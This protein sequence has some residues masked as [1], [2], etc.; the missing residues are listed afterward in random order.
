[1]SAESKSQHN[2]H[3]PRYVNTALCP[4][5]P[6]DTTATAFVYGGPAA[7]TNQLAQ[8]ERQSSVTDWIEEATQVNPDRLSNSTSA[9]EAF[10]AV[11]VDRLYSDVVHELGLLAQ[12]GGSV[13]GAAAV[14]KRVA[15][16]HGVAAAAVV[17]LP[18]LNRAELEEFGR[19]GVSR[20][21]VR[22][23]L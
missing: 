6:C 21:T 14:V 9:L 4:S 19:R 23:E 15:L 13:T 16:S 1:M 2:A 12:R 20:K 11:D 22:G 7:N 5:Q 18:R 17:P 8:R 10:V 3:N